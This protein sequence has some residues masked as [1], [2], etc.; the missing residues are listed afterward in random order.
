MARESPKR[1]QLV[2]VRFWRASKS[3]SEFGISV[4]G[5]IVDNTGKQVDDILDREHMPYHFTLALYEPEV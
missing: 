1:M 3:E 4:N 5:S 2:A